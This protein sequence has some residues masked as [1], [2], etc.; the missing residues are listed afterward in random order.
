MISSETPEKLRAIIQDT[1][2]QLFYLKRD[3]WKSGTRG[4]CDEREIPER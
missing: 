1:Y 3:D 4:E 2:P